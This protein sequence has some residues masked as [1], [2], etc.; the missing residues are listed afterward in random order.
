MKPSENVCSLFIKKSKRGVRVGL[1]HQQ[2]WLS[3]HDRP[4]TPYDKPVLGIP[5]SISM[6]CTASVAEYRL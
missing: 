6:F 1:T 5:T 2:S 4:W 3:R